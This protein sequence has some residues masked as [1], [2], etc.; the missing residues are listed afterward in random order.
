MKI[1]KYLKSRFILQ[2]QIIVKYDIIYDIILYI[3]IRKMINIM[4]RIKH[5][6]K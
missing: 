2:R 6:S 3:I 4:L 1:G 5:I